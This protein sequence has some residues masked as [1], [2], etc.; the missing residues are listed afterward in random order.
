[1]VEVFSAVLSG[2]MTS[3]HVIE[4]RGTTDK[5]QELGFF[6][7]AIDVSSFEDVDV[8]KAGIDQLIGELKASRKMEGVEE[9]FMPGEIEYKKQLCEETTLL[10]G[11]CSSSSSGECSC[12]GTCG[13][14]SR[15]WG[16]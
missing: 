4:L 9:I 7:G 12:C 11:L 14:S 2:A 1:M 10:S 13:T 3:P 16:W 8:F 15:S 6:V 5:C